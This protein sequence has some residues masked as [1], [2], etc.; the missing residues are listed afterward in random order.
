VLEEAAEVL[1]GAAE[2][3]ERAAGVLEGGAEARGEERARLMLG[4][5]PKL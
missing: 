2:V 5:T 3:L 1:V 4:S